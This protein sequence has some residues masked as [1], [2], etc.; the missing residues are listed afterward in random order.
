MVEGRA[1]DP[2]SDWRVRCAFCSGLFWALRVRRSKLEGWR[3]HGGV[4][5]AAGGKDMPSQGLLFLTFGGQREPKGSQKP[6]KGGLR[7]VRGSQKGA[8]ARPREPKSMP[9]ASPNGN[10][11]QVAGK[12]LQ[13]EAQG[14]QKHAKILEIVGFVLNMWQKPWI[15]QISF[16]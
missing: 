12:M 15:F 8:N 7:G 1:A 6:A 11:E 5:K 9:K 3:S 16:E 14:A 13:S 10:P 4:S 2:V